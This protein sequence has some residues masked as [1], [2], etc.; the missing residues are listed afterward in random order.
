MH[1]SNHENAV[2]LHKTKQK[3]STHVVNQ[4]Y[5]FM[6]YRYYHKQPTQ[7]FV[8]ASHDNLKSVAL[9]FC[10]VFPTSYAT[11]RTDLPTAETVFEKT[12]FSQNGMG[13]YF[14]NGDKKI[15]GLLI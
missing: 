11:K 14:C 10:A 13:K 8:S 7:S 12:F 5:L 4:P 3:C 15:Y 1:N 6:Q 9:M 2:N